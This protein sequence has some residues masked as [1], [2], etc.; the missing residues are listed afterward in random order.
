MA[1]R[2]L[3]SDK[4]N[5]GLNNIV[6]QCFLLNRLLDRQMSELSVKFTM[7]HTS[8]ILHPLLAHAPLKLADFIGDYQDQRN[9]LT[10][11]RETPLDNT[12][13]SNVLD[14]FEKFLDSMKELEDMIQE[15]INICDEEADLT[16]KVF[17]QDFLIKLIPFSAQAILLCD[18]IEAYGDTSFGRM[19]FDSNI[20]DFI[21]APMLVGKG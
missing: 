18:K 10:A 12:D 21:V 20:K 13:Y 19:M 6:H 11:Y 2:C 7:N 4:V 1:N 16:T 9:A 14:M 15:V 8:D 5:T 17:L 3:V